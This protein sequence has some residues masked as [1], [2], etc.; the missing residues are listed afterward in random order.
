MD[1][2]AAYPHQFSG[3]MQQR[4]LI[5]LALICEPALLLADEPTTALD[6]TIQAQ[7]LNLMLKINQDHRTAVILVTHD[8]GVAAEFCDTISVMYGGRIVEQGPVD[9]VVT[10]PL[11]PY[12]QGS[13]HRSKRSTNKTH[14]RQCAR[15]HQLAARMC[16]CTTLPIGPPS[17]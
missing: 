3:G 1:R 12:T 4:A 13:I 15:C 17:M 11:H 6:V 2:Y 9:E 14:P 7:I 16:L 10:N 5:A 8:L